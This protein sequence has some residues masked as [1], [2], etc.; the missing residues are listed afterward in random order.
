MAIPTACCTTAT[1]CESE[2]DKI[3]A[4]ATGK[5]QEAWMITVTY[6]EMRAHLIK[7]QNDMNSAGRSVEEED[8]PMGL[9]AGGVGAGLVFFCLSVVAYAYLSNLGAGIS[10]A[11]IIVPIAERI[12]EQP[13][14]PS[15]PGGPGPSI[16][17]D[18]GGRR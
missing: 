17:G 12:E 4:E 14:L 3:I 5:P 1:A 18:G 9:I 10:N 16:G 15:G 8:T 6:D 13:P 11:P 2:L 7:C